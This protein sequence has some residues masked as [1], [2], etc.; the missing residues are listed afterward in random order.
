MLNGMEKTFILTEIHWS[1]PCFFIIYKFTTQTKL[2]NTL[3]F[4][5]TVICHGMQLL[6]VV[7]YITCDK[8]DQIKK[9]FEELNLQ[10]H[11]VLG[12]TQLIPSEYH[13]SATSG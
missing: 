13:I 9:L 6:W 1:V 5:V 3:F 8:P 2:K 12:N 7:Y 11:H 10:E 4:H